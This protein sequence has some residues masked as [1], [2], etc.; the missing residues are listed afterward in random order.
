MINSPFSTNEKEVKVQELCVYSHVFFE[1]KSKW[2]PIKEIRMSHSSF[3]GENIYTLI[4][5]DDTIWSVTE[6]KKVKMIIK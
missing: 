1:D 3:L 2:M 6:N 5:N 4:S